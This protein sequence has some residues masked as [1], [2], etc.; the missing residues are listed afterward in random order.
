M[1]KRYSLLFLM[2]FSFV[3]V[4]H[5]LYAEK[6]DPSTNSFEVREHKYK[7]DV[8]DFAGDYPNLE[9]I[10][11]DARRKKRVEMVLTGNY[12]LLEK[13]NYEGSFGSLIGKLTGSFPALSAVNFMCSSA[14]MQ[15]DLCGEWQKNCEILIRGSTGNIVVTLPK[16]IGVA[17]YTKTGTTGKV[18]NNNG[19]RKKGWGWMN[20]T[21][22]NELY[23]N[24]E[25]IQLTV[26]IEVTKAKIILN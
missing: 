12:P 6:I 22:V 17:V 26:V 10:D 9:N 20:K 18:V 23:G 11:I 21:Y 13:I 15:L 5:Q 1:T 25:A 2:F 8:F 3:A 7:V 19:F 16:D 14:A 4:F 24:E